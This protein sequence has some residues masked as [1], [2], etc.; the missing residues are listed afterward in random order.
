MKILYI[1]HDPNMHGSTIS[2]INMLKGLVEK[3]IDATVVVPD[4][5]QPSHLFIEEMDLCHV[6]VI[7]SYLIQSK[8]NPTVK[9]ECNRV[10]NK[11][12]F[13]RQKYY[14]YKLLV[15]IIKK[16][17]PDIVHTNVGVIHE[18]MWAARRCRIPHVFHIREYQD[19]DFGWYIFPSKFFFSH[20]I[21]PLSTK[22]IFISK[23]LC[24]NFSQHNKKNSIVIYN[25]IYSRKVILP[26]VKKE[27]Y[28]LCASRISPEKGLDDVIDCFSVFSKENPEYRLKIAG[29]GPSSYLVKLKNKAQENGCLSKI[30]FLGHISDL[31]LL[32]QQAKALLVASFF[33]GFGRMTAEAAFCGCLVVGRNTGGTKEILEQIGGYLFA[34][35]NEF[36]KQLFDIEALSDAEYENKKNISQIQ[37]INEYSIETNVE[38][39][40]NVYREML[41]L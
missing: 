29:E 31:K 27:R 12:F 8:Y 39:V 18:G 24:K 9:Q 10:K 21:L 4:D 20:I 32:Y 33:E 35:K 25:G 2:F 28:F 36:I 19:K 14:S 23:D 1:L 30:D 40:N 5:I 15:D 16:E 11:I 17:K 41:S 37:A 13:Y 26:S 6:R 7:S 22:N 3:G 34:D 38:F